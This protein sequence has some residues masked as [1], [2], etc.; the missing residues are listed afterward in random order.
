MSKWEK[1]RS[2]PF[3]EP[4][5]NVKQARTEVY[6]INLRSSSSWLVLTNRLK[7]RLFLDFKVSVYITFNIA[8]INLSP[9]KQLSEL[10]H[11]Q[12]NNGIQD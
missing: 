10:N 8:K 11:S 7:G 4:T 6:N 12:R 5:S 1:L 9:E 2:K 3:S